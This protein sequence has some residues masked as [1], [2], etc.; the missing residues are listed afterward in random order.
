MKTEADIVGLSLKDFFSSEI[1][2]IAV[3]PFLVTMFVVYTLFFTGASILV[4]NIDNLKVEQTTVSQGNMQEHDDSMMNS[5]SSFF[6]QSAAISWIVNILIYSLGT[7]MM[8]YVSIFISLI[9]IGFLTPYIVDKIRQKHYANI[10]L[11][12]DISILSSVFYLLKSIII[13]LILFF[14]LIPFYF[15]P[16]IQI[17]AL[18]L[19]FYY[20]FHKLLNFD[21]ASTIL[22]KNDLKA[23]KNKHTTKLR[24]RTL[25]LYLLSLIPFMSL[26]LPVYYI[27]Y[28][29]HGYFASIKE[30]NYA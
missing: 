1:L 30:E 5:V 17:V 13:M 25:K 26:I 23:F 15:I 27:V 14:A 9:V 21:V 2:K 11:E 16:I 22:N 29:S 8:I 3:I 18:A 7:I 10:S 12:G 28:I 4:D 19:P 6:L 24:L 20:L